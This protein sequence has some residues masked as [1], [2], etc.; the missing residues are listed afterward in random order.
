MVRGIPTGSFRVY[1]STFG[2]VNE[3]YDNIPCLGSCSSLVGSMGT[4]V[5]VS[6]GATTGNIDF[7]LTPGAAITGTVSDDVTASPLSGVTVFAVTSVGGTLTFANS[8]FTNALGQYSLAGLPAGNYFVATDGNI[9]YRHEVYDNVPCPG[10]SCLTTAILAGTPITVAAG[11]TTANRNFGLSPRDAITGTITDASTGTPLSGVS[12]SV[13]SRATSSF[14]RSA[15]T[16]TAGVYRV[17]GLPN[18]SYVA[19]TSNSRGYRNEIYNDIPCS[20]SCSSQTAIASG[21]PIAVTGS[22]ADATGIDF[23]LASQTAPPASPTNL[24]ART[25]GFTTTFFWNAS[26]TSNAAAA[27][28]YV[29]EAGVAPGH[30]AVSFPVNDT[31]FTV[32]GVPVG[33]FYIRVRGVNAFGAGPASTEY[34]LRVRSD[35]AQPLEAP[36]NVLAFMSGGRLTL[37]WGA[38]AAGGAPTGYVVEAGSASGVANLAT[39]GVNARSFTFNPVPN[40]FYFLRVR[41]RTAAEVGPP[42]AEAMIVV[43]GVASPPGPP[44]FTSFSVSGSTVTLTWSA[45]TFGMATSYIVEAGSDSGLANLGVLNTGNTNLTLTVPNVPNGMYYVR[46]RAVNALGRSIVSNERVNTVGPS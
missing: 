1:T 31:S 8:A 13:Y 36:T 30:T 27:T 23:A 15:A 25:T 16:N 10:T 20:G 29:L 6:L 41:A 3:I 43:G 37:T 5:A 26:T 35:G 19:F 45:P 40:G 21:A 18:G 34:V 39:L 46:I 38:P 33:T 4:A 28:S 14:V 9:G 2:H 32:A 7:A 22:V 24:R 42:S 12:V 17:P 11:A 44:G